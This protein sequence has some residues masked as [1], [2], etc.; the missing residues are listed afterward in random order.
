MN[1]KKQKSAVII[2][3]DTFVK[4]AKIYPPGPNSISAENN[5]KVMLGVE[6]IMLHLPSATFLH[7]PLKHQ[8]K[9]SDNQWQDLEINGFWGSPSSTISRFQCFQGQ[10]CNLHI[11]V[12]K[13]LADT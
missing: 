12:Y 5:Q 3:N 8:A 11:C 10:D 7:F 4:D 1:E 2:A 9:A 13:V 6:Q